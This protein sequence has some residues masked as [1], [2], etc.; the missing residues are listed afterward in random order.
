MRRGHW[1]NSETR[2]S[3]VVLPLLERA[4][5]PAVTDASQF[6]R[7]RSQHASSSANDADATSTSSSDD[8]KDGSH[9]GEDGGNACADGKHHGS[10]GVAAASRKW[11]AT[12]TRDH[13]SVRAASAARRK[14][15]R[16]AQ[17]KSP[18]AAMT[19]Q[20]VQSTVRAEVNGVTAPP[21]VKPEHVVQE[22]INK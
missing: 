21:T 15:R 7:Q 12:A 2:R 17:L 10:D 1:Q 20:A 16:Q 11:T 5:A 19:V 3:E 6:R 14:Q 13:D 9:H 18:P 22:M 4:R 8:C